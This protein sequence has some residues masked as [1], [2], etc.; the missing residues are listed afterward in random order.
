M[1]YEKVS[2]KLGTWAPLFKPFIESPAFD[3][4]FTNLKMQ[5]QAGRKIVPKSED[6][7][8]SFTLCDKDKVKAI[9]F[10]MDPYPSLGKDGTIIAD[11][12]PMSC[13]NTGILQPSLQLFYNAIEDSYL[14]FDPEFDARPDNSYLLSEEH[15]L[16]M[17]T[18]LTVEV[19]K[20]G[21]HAQLW[22]GFMKY[23]IEEVLN[24]HFR[25]LPIILCGQSAQKLERYFNPML[26]YVKKIEHPVAASYTNRLW[27]Y[28][29]VFKWIDNII[30]Q[31]NGKEFVP[32]WY[33]KKGEAG[34][35]EQ[36]LPDWVTDSTIKHH[37]DEPGKPPLPKAQD[38]GLP[39]RDE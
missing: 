23:F 11:G 35:G 8:R 19:Q 6:V 18:S 31:N 32:R 15:I 27:D 20:V 3:A 25:G 38:L 26:H 39:W 10:L 5:S 13:R 34:S 28:D 7:F 14:G 33:R 24:K 9:M 12:C 36:A 1:N 22:A 37:E 30:L 29:D 21:S 17:N 16:L 4:I 2:D